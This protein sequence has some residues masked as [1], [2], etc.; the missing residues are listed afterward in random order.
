MTTSIL[1]LPPHP[2]TTPNLP[3]TIPP[4]NKGKTAT[5]LLRG[6][7]K[8]VLEEAERSLHDALCCV[9]CLKQ[10]PALLPGGAAPEME[11]SHHLHA[12]AR[13]LS[14]M[15]SYCV[16]WAGPCC[17]RC[18]VNTE[19]CRLHI[20]ARSYTY[21][22]LLVH[23]LPARTLRT[24]TYSCAFFSYAYSANAYVDYA[25][26]PCANFRTHTLPTHTLH[27]TIVYLPTRR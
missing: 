12:W 4:Q 1:F 24:N 10:L 22:H 11:V 15:E 21:L 3:A 5:V 23:N 9:R 19:L 8:M 18:W 7:T 16:R 26:S 14:G 25:Y 27:L 17:A 13:T 2:T 6:S 20:V